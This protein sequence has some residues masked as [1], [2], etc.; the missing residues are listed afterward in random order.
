MA[1][2]VRL[3]PM[4][5]E[6]CHEM[7]R[8]FE[9]DPALLTNEADWKPY[10]YHADRVDAYFKHQ[11]EKN[12]LLFAI[13][14]DDEPVGEVSLKE[15]DDEAKT[16]VLSIILKNDSW[17]GRGIGKQAIRLALE[18]AFQ[19]LDLNTVLADALI[20]NTRSQHVLDQV[21]F[22]FIHQDDTFRYYR[23]Q[24]ERTPSCH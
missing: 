3:V 16:C 14:H 7:F 9:N 8:G 21:G 4:T 12:R 2:I 13:M 20:K 23:Y 5:K 11:L 19:V 10:T 24:R 17:K 22:V 6:L 15:F 18:Y 1:E